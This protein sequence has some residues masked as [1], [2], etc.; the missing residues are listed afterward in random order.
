MATELKKQRILVTGPTGQVALP[1]T[2]ALAK[3]NDVWGLA[4]FS[5]DSLRDQPALGGVACI[6]SALE[7]TDFSD[8]PGDF[9]YVLNFAVTKVGV[10]DFDRVLAANA[11]SVGL[12]MARCKE[13]KAFL[14]CS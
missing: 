1:I 13:A 7:T 4:R 14:H 5:D 11:E 6:P 8:L 2:L 9:D 10:D 12:L 3:S